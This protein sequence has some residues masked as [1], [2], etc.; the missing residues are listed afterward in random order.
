MDKTI[1]IVGGTG[2]QG[3]PVAR[4]MQKEGF[5][6]RIL[7]RD[8]KKARDKLGDAFEYHEGDV[9]D[10]ESLSE[11]SR[12]CYGVHINLNATTRR[13]LDAIELEGTR[14]SARAAKTNDVG[15]ISMISASWV[16]RE[17]LRSTFVRYKWICEEAIRN[18]GVPYTIFAPT[19]FMNGLPAY[20][21]GD[22]AMI[23][24]RQTQKIHWLSVDEYATLVSG[25]Y[26]SQNAVNKKFP[27]YGPRSYTLE[28]ALTMYCRKKHP[29]VSLYRTSLSIFHFMAR[30]SFDSRM[31]YVAIMMEAL[32]RI[33]DKGEMPETELILGKPALG[34]EQWVSTL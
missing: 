9:R 10:L 23:I 20:I 7:S 31:K 2:H 26:K 1:L 22:R 32:S 25:A 14:N 27:I 6:I 12:G 33:D 21:K 30:I 29:D 4:Q 13:E 17:N 8:I 19:H 3:K 18:S 28:E 24:G 11:A 16:K 34:L 15:R 5:R